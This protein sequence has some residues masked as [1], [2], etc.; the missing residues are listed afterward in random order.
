MLHVALIKCACETVIIAVYLYTVHTCNGSSQREWVSKSNLVLPV[1]TSAVDVIAAT[2]T[3]QAL[4]A[5]LL[6][7]WHTA[8]VS[9]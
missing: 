1:K 4:S 6:N 7:T 8:L 5:T 2:K 9:D 3:D